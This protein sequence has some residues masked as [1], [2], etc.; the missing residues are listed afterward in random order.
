MYQLTIIKDTIALHPT[1]FS[2]PVQQAIKGELNKKYADRV[3]PNVGLGVCVFDLLSVSEG[4]VRY[5]TFRLVV[6]RPFVS[7]VIVGTIK[8]CTE[9]VVIV[10]TGFFDD[11]VVP[12]SLL[13]HPH[14]YDP[15]EKTHFWLASEAEAEPTE[16]EMLDS[17]LTDRL[18]LDRGEI[19][20]V[21]IEDDEF[22]DDEPGPPKAVDGVY[23]RAKARRPPYEITAS[24]ATSGLGLIAWWNPQQ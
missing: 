21:R 16:T 13:P 4:K 3:I 18:Y 24:M 10:S 23:T 1:T 17:E 7:E 5:V 11:I 8:D 22:H 14:A 2:Q 15:N 12:A 9:K 6:F 19:V 20:R